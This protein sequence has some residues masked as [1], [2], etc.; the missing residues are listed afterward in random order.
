[1]IITAVFKLS[2]YTVANLHK[3]KEEQKEIITDLITGFTYV[4]SIL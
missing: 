3:S 1:M 4:D 2:G